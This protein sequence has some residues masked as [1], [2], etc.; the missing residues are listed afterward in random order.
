MT[1]IFKDK[2]ESD[3]IHNTLKRNILH[4]NKLTKE[5]KDQFN[6]NIKTLK[7]VI[8]EDTRKN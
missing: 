4:L 3:I 1:N 6:A 2:Q 5:V 8:K 7:N